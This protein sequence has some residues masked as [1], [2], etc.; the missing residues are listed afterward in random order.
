MRLESI[1]VLNGTSFFLLAKYRQQLLCA[2]HWY[3]RDRGTVTR[4]VSNQQLQK[5][6]KVLMLRPTPQPLYAPLKRC[7]SSLIQC[8]YSPLIPEHMGIST[9]EWSCE[10]SEDQP[11]CLAQCHH[12]GRGGIELHGRVWVPLSLLPTPSL[13]CSIS[14]FPSPHPPQLQLWTLNRYD[15]PVSQERNQHR[16]NTMKQTF[17]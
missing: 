11:H 13:P 5:W 8:I 17:D 10:S 4:H 12:D 7:N 6:W 15:Y 16:H 3:L 14:P 2:R 1:F 9:P